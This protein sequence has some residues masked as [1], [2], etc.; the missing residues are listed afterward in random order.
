MFKIKI[1]KRREGL[2]RLT[3]L[4][5]SLLNGLIVENLKIKIIKRILRMWWPRI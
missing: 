4:G 5:T 1:N 3:S 2:N